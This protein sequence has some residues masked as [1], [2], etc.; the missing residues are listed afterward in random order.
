M[1][2]WVYRNRFEIFSILLLII[3]SL[4]SFLII[5]NHDSNKSKY[6]E[7]KELT[8]IVSNVVSIILISVGAIL[9]YFK[10][11]KGRIF[12]EKIELVAFAKVIEEDEKHNSVFFNVKISNIGN[13]AIHRP[14][15][16]MKVAYLS[17]EGVIVEKDVD[18]L[19]EYSEEEK[20][21]SIIEPRAH[22]NVHTLHKVEKNIWALKFSFQITSSK[23]N[24][25]LRILTVPNKEKYEHE[26]G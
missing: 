23:N 19:E 2:K 5:K 22:Y 4:L 7:F 17:E 6:S 18:I 11:F 14:D 21:W 24:S 12:T 8:D 13:V 9:S 1:K 10:F 25:W 20:E 15:S 26:Q 3:I 16:Y